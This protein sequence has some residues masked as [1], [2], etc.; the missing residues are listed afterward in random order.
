MPDRTPHWTGKL[1]REGD[2]LRGTGTE[3]LSGWPVELEVRREADGTYTWV[4]YLGPTPD[5][6]RLPW[7]DA[8]RNDVGSSKPLTG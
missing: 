5:A 2:E 4:M 7:E 3:R 6:L 1:T 8:D